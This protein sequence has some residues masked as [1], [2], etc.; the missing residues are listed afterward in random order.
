[1]SKTKDPNPRLIAVVPKEFKL[2]IDT[3]AAENSMSTSKYIV[4]ALQAF[5]ETPALS[6]QQVQQHIL[7]SCM[8]LTNVKNELN[9]FYPD[10]NTKELEDAKNELSMLKDYFK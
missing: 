5:M 10:Y 7:N 4:T 6:N 8:F 1:M 2:I 3:T 9:L